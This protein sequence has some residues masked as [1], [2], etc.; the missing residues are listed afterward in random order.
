M[1]PIDEFVARLKKIPASTFTVAGVRQFLV[2]HPVSPESLQRYLFFQKDHYTRNLIFKNELFELLA[3]C[4]EAGQGSEVHNHW[5]QN[6]WMAVPI[7]SLTARNYRVSDADEVRQTCRLTPTGLFILDGRNPMAVDPEEPVHEVFCS[8]KNQ[9]R[10]VSL[11]I[12]SLPFDSCLVYSTEDGTY[13]KV[14]LS[15]YSLYG[16]Q[17]DPSQ[18][19]AGKGKVG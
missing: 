19:L 18:G 7:G 5:N 2:Q 14:K 15:Y 8:A 4:W 3:L 12:Y 16:E 17:I 9:Q 6:C 1:V 11:H 10:S 13:R